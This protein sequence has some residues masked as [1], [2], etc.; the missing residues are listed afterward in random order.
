MKLLAKSGAHRPR[1]ARSQPAL[2]RRSRLR[3]LRS[4]SGRARPS[5]SRF[6]RGHRVSLRRPPVHRNEQRRPSLARLASGRAQRTD[7]PPVERRRARALLLGSVVFAPIV[8]LTALPWSTLLSQHTQLSSDTA[9]MNQLQVE[10][11]ALAAQARQL[12]DTATQEALARQ[13]YG[14]VKPGQTAYD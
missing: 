8:V 10:N 5:L 6:S 1:H 2:A 11:R 14:L 12:S 3:P 9:E 13:D 7:R 4:L